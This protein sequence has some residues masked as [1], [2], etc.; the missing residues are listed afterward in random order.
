[1]PKDCND[2]DRCTKIGKVCN[3]KTGRCIKPKKDNSCITNPH[4]CINQGKVCNPKTGRCINKPKIQN[5]KTNKLKEE[6][7]KKTMSDKLY[8]FSK[9]KDVAP[10]KGTN[11]TVS[12]SSL[13]TDLTAIK[14]WRKVLS[15]F[16]LAPFKFDGYTWNTIEHVF[17]A[18][19]IALVDPEKALW[20]T[21]E[22]GHEIGQGD[23]N[24][25]RKN[26]KLVVLDKTHLTTWAK[27]RNDIMFEAALEKY[28]Q[29][30]D[31]LK[32]LKATNCAEL[33]HVVMRSKPERFVHLEK[34]RSIL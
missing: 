14:D 32:V 33:W 23:G 13:Y 6:M 24:V 15:N 34:I 12:D 17:Q 4:K 3:P 11:E 8:F 28:K 30:K 31:S 22:S 29:H 25:A 1:M 27:L 20:F 2:T 7:C 9:S 10:G 26:R 18:K 16:H 19:K 5:L 21:V